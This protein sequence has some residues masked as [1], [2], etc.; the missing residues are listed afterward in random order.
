MEYSVFLNRSLSQTIASQHLQ[1][2][3]SSIALRLKARKPLV[4]WW[5]PMDLPANIFQLWVASFSRY[6]VLAVL[7]AIHHL[8]SSYVTCKFQ[9]RFLHFA[10]IIKVSILS[11]F[12]LDFNPHRKTI[13]A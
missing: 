4:C 1:S 5:K 9:H 8:P 12:H 10:L 13:K 7:L 11:S 2:F 6:V 3:A